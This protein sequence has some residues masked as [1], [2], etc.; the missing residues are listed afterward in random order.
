VP[1][2]ASDRIAIVRKVRNFLASLAVVPAFGGGYVLGVHHAVQVIPTSSA[3][4]ISVERTDKLRHDAALTPAKIVQM[5]Q[6]LCDSQELLDLQV[7]KMPEDLAPGAINPEVEIL[8]A[9]PRARR[10]ME[11]PHWAEWVQKH[12]PPRHDCH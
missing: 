4:T 7:H 6:E 3:A 9:D 1:V 10:E 5:R 8:K 11:G 2:A 12:L